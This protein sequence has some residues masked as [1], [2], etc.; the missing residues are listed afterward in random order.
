MKSFQDKEQLIICDDI[1]SKVFTRKRLKK[2]L[3]ADLDL[4]L[5]IKP[6]D[7][8]VHIEHW[9]GIFK[10]IIKRELPDP[11]WNIIKEYI[12][13]EYAWE[14]KLFVPI[15]EVSRVNKYLWIENPKLTGLGW[16]IWEKKLQKAK[17][18]AEEIAQ[19]L[20][21]IY[22]NRKMQKWFSFISDSKK[23]DI[24]KNSFPY[25]HTEDQSITINEIL[26]D[27]EKETPMDRLVVW[28]VWFWKTEIA[29]NSIYRSY[30]NKKQSILIVPLVVL[31]YEHYEKAKERFKPF[32]LKVWV[33]T[34]LETE[35]KASET[36]RK[37]SSGELDLVIWTHKLLSD[38][39]IYKDLWLIVTDEEHKFWVSDKEKIKEFKTTID[40][41][42]MSATPIPRSLNMA[43]SNLKQISI[44]KT[45]PF[46]RQDID[47]II[48]RFSE[49]IVQWAWELEFG[50]NWQMFFVHNRVSSIE[51]IKTVLKNIFP[52]K[53]IIITHGQ[54]PWNEL[55][56]R[57][58]DFKNK[59]YDI[60]LSTT[61]IENWIDFSNV[62]TIIINNAEQF[63]LS[64]I[65][66]LRWRVWR[67]DK[68]WYCHLLYKQENIKPETA[69]RLKTIVEH[70]Y[71]WAW[72]EL[73]MKDLE[74]RG[75]WDLLGFRQSGQSSSIWINLY[76]K[77]IEEKILELQENNPLLTYSTDKEATN[78]LLKNRIET[79]IDIDIPVFIPD[80]FF[81]SELD[82]INF[83]REI[84]LISDLDELGEIKKDLYSNN[85]EIEQSTSNLFNL[86]ELKLL[87]GKYLITNIKKIWINFQIDFHKNLKLEELKKFLDLDKQVKF[88]V[89]SAIRLRSEVKNFANNKNFIEYMLSLFKRSNL[90]NKIKL[91]WKK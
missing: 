42:A 38:K 17:Q 41:L 84:E 80:N 71:V 37:L 75:W 39:I 10:D 45:P 40:S 83:Y 47:T 25:T 9:I 67:S 43:L 31:A 56:K 11:K 52:E 27:M 55:E 8:V 30:I 66:Q 54:L 72:F 89:I 78:N 23:E 14:D 3:S 90:N 5:K 51:N 35:K 13:I 19:E 79:K 29:F 62:N 36:I 1:L 82:K 44:L 76:L 61:V 49:S 65:H 53:K 22:A 46:G 68:K 58:I 81:G 24:F 33:L 88:K 21:E 4:L 77:I 70:S 63:W 26:D 85:S 50:R 6:W 7:Y 16:M 64:Q 28:D 91:K 12:E 32:G 18:E 15:T 57:I 73:A 48:N 34:R 86:L 20:I 74:I 69:K 59:K 60:L 2:N 87:S